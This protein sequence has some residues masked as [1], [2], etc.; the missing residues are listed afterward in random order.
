MPN[1]IEDLIA[2]NEILRKKLEDCHRKMELLESSEQ[3]FQHIFLNSPD[4]IAISSVKTGK[5]IEVNPA[6][7]KVAGYTENEVIGKSSVEID[8]WENE[9]QRAFFQSKIYSNEPISNFE[10][11]FRRKTNELAIIS[12]SVDF[13]EY[14]NEHCLLIVGRDITSLKQAEN[15]ARESE[16]KYEIL[17]E[18]AAESIVVVQD[19][20]IKFFNKK[21]IDILGYT[22]E[23]IIDKPFSFFIH[24]DD[25]NLVSERN[26]DRLNGKN[27]PN[28]YKFRI[29][30][31][32]KKI[33]WL[34]M[35]TVLIDWHGKPATMSF[36]TDITEFYL[37]EQLLVQSEKKY[38]TL[39]NSIGDPIFIHQLS[40]NN[41]EN[42]LE[43]N[44]AALAKYGYSEKEFEEKSINDLCICGVQQKDNNLKE[45]IEH[46]WSNYETVHKDKNGNEFDV[47]LNSS[48]VEIEGNKLILTLCKDISERKI[49]EKV[50]IENEQKFRK[51]YENTGLPI[52]MATLGFEILSV[53]SAYCKMFEY[54]G[55]EL[56]GKHIKEL[57]HPDSW[58]ENVKLQT[59]L[60]NG[61]I[62]S[63]KLEK[64]FITKSGK[65]LTGILSANLIFEE[66][67]KP[68]YILAN[69]IDVTDVRKAEAEILSL[70]KDLETRVETRTQELQEANKK[71]E[72]FVYSVSHDLRS[73]LRHI[74]GFT[75][76]LEKILKMPDEQ[77]THYLGKIKGASKK[78]SEMIDSLL[79]FSRIGKSSLN[80]IKVDLTVVVST[81]VRRLEIET[82][83]RMIK[84]TINKLPTIEADLN[85][86]LIVF[87][88]LLSNALKYSSKKEITLINIGM[89]ENEKNTI[90]VSDNGVGFDMEYYEKLFS[91]FQR[92]HSDDEFEGTGIGLAHVK[93]IINKHGGEIWA[94]SKKGEGAT[95][96]LKF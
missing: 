18:Y 82:G 22:A 16:K 31:K 12:V 94:E 39:F 80:L 26:Q 27:P 32:F 19:L 44:S 6:F 77:I 81:V 95:F 15:A 69:V 11:Y 20:V 7:L 75:S 37:I 47:E 73:P 3:R 79:K 14:K 61:Q 45:I 38:R 23:E 90:F 78:M 40:E 88:N 30:T 21:T 91:V 62:D 9:E 36:F 67:N 8:L 25:L 71:L 46:G 89:V 64:K 54:T 2:E 50:L 85:L 56:V 70:N 63:Y 5:Y 10:A 17:V 33:K 28:I 48:V 13:I 1:N 86:M 59:L 43:V 96:Y 92:L 52:G 57:T 53:N 58:S 65:I 49:A 42:F 66:D 24:P 4:I 60:N 93:Q 87:E 74:S 55:K 76:M 29:I 41:F 34:E 84:W 72:S 83:N 68:S 51:I 35:T